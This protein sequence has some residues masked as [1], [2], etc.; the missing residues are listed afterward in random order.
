MFARLPKSPKQ[1]K[2]TRTF[3][4]CSGSVPAEYLKTGIRHPIEVVNGCKDHEPGLLLRLN[5]LAAIGLVTGGLY[6]KGQPDGNF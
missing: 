6:W 4:P 1:A 5:V 2:I 3:D